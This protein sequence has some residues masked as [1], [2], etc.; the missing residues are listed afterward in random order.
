MKHQN[1]IELNGKRYDALT[2][3]LLGNSHTP[4]VAAAPPVAPK[5]RAIDGFIRSAKP[6]PAAK[7]HSSIPAPVKVPVKVASHPASFHADVAPAA[8]IHKPVTA[9]P[10]PVK[11]TTM[12]A[13]PA[14][15]PEAASALAPLKAKAHKPASHVLAHKPQ[16]AQTLMRRAVHKPAASLKPAIKVQAPAEVASKPVSAIAHKRSAYQ[17]DPGRLEHAQH[18]NK[19][20][21]IRHFR[22]QAFAV[23][24]APM[25]RPALARAAATAHSIAMPVV[26]L[27]AASA[28]LPHTD[29]FAAAIARSTSHEQPEHK[30]PSRRSRHRR[31][32]NVMAGLAAFLVIGGFIAY[33][34]MPNI[35]LHVAS[36]QAGFGAQLPGYAP[37]GF[38]LRG[39]VQRAGNTVSMRYQSGDQAYTITQ[40]A[41]NWNSQTLVENT[42]ALS[43]HHQTLQ[44]GGRTIYVYNGSNAVW[45]DGNV[46]YDVT[47]NAPLSADD[48][49][50][51]ARSL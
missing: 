21:T 13:K 6:K 32:V 18:I 4:V 16:H 43:D 37:T 19:H 35:E 26:P 14:L 17:V 12:A 23:G 38:A 24:P 8:K 41:S 40:Q 9:V 49:T 34:N 7:A 47:G 29:M 48:I 51:L 3:A 27:Q 30:H 42:L 45:V 39:G 2:G 10:A 46:R 28:K 31:T 15:S 11:V 22:P 5:G 50:A 36:I 44:A 25:P 20:E 1:V 33:L